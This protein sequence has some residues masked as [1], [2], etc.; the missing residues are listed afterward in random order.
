[1]LGADDV[2]AMVHLRAALDWSC[3]Q[4]ALSW[5]LRAATSFAC[6]LQRQALGDDAWAI[7]AP[8]YA[9]FTKGFETPELRTARA[10]GGVD[11]KLTRDASLRTR[12][13]RGGPDGVRV[14]R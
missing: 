12:A 7:L 14:S 6:M 2:Q 4:G 3:R 8:V 1:M 13:S 10:P 9:R 5:E 11:P